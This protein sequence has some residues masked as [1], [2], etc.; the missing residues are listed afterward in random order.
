MTSGAEPV[1][2]PSLTRIPAKERLY[3]RETYFREGFGDAQDTLGPSLAS[4]LHHSALLMLKP[5]GL[6]A[7]KLR[8]TCAFLE[9]HGFRVVGVRELGFDRLRWRELW[10]YQLT[11]A[12]LDRLAVNEYFLSAG[13]ALLLLL[14]DNGRHPLPASVRLG[15]LKGSA[16][17]AG[18]KPGTLRGALGQSNRV[19]SLVHTADEPADVVRELGLLFDGPERR[20]LLSGLARGRPTAEHTQ[21]LA[22]ALDR[23]GGPGR[24]LS[25]A[26]SLRRVRAAVEARRAAGGTPA[27]RAERVL[28]RLAEIREGGLIDWRAFA[29]D[30]EALELTVDRWDLAVLG[31]HC[32]RCDEADH[33]KLLE[34]PDPEAWIRTTGAAGENGPDHL[35]PSREKVHAD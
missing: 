23:Y 2:W 19:L 35:P 27:G 10:R 21:E 28:A 12:T 33:P 26:E 17:P 1:P 13:P 22:A 16:G 8:P 6:A 34:G 32:I 11:T 15:T 3:A 9:E 25:G 30:L 24:S 14:C 18:R 4:A 31:S 5:D 7:G 20:A 29:R